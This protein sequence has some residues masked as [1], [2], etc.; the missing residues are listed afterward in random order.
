MK[1]AIS[2]PDD[3][4]AAASSRALEM[5]ISRSAFLAAAAVNY[6]EKLDR[7]SLTLRIDSALSAAESDD[8]TQDAVLLGHRY[9]QAAAAED[10]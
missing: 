10:W 1:T 4:Y 9:L 6:L 8:S 3:I 5:G 7:A 2:L